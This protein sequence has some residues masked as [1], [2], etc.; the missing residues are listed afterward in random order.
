MTFE[1]FLGKVTE[2]FPGHQFRFTDGKIAGFDLFLAKSDKITV[3]YYDG[4]SNKWRVE[5][6]K[7]SFYPEVL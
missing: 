2:K 6:E 5:I 7:I 4:L 1:Q 3:S